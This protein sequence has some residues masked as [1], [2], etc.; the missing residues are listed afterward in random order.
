MARRRGAACWCS[1]ARSPRKSLTQAKREPGVTERLPVEYTGYAW[2]ILQYLQALRKK[3]IELAAA[4]S[5]LSLSPFHKLFDLSLHTHGFHEHVL[6]PF[7]NVCDNFLH[8]LDL[9]NAAT[10]PKLPLLVDFQTH[11]KRLPVELL[12]FVDMLVDSLRVT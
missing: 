6:I 2:R 7:S 9:D 4:L 1:G 11:L 10:M 8:S 3:V 5:A 12:Q